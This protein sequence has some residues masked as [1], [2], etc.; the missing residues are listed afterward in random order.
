MKAWEKEHA[1]CVECGLFCRIEDGSFYIT[2]G[3]PDFVCNTC[4]TYEEVANGPS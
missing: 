4:D 2:G 3:Q 1:V